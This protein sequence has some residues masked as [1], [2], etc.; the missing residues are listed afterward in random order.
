[1]LVEIRFLLMAGTLPIDNIA[2]LLALGVAA[3]IRI[4]TKFD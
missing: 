2:W 3:L 4:F 1:L